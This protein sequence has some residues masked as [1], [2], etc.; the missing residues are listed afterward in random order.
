VVSRVLAH[1]GSCDY[2]PLITGHL[3]VRHMALMIPEETC[4]C[5]CDQPSIQDQTVN[6]HVYAAQLCDL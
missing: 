6:I 2:K 1:I 5:V 4:V 3:G